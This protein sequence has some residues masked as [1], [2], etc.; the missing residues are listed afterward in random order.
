MSR[1]P[2]KVKFVIDNPNDNTM[3]E[4]IATCLFMRAIHN[5]SLEIIEKEMN[6]NNEEIV[7]LVQ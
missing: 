2:M 5:P 6:G 1:Q 7:G 3:N 4:Q